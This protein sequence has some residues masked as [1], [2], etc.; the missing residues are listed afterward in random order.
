MWDQLAAVGPP[1]FFAALPWT[2]DGL[3]L[4]RGITK[5][6]PAVLTGTPRGE[7]AAAQ[8]KAWC[9]R[10][11]GTGVPVVALPPRLKW[12][13]AGPGR[14]LIDD[15]LRGRAAWVARGGT[16]IWHRTA[17]LTLRELRLVLDGVANG[18]QR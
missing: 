11:L 6:R 18:G 10:E 14:V 8:K 7:W 5:H 4:W 15:D 3:V 2:A 13:Y 1:G 16:F 12:M 9:A 17:D